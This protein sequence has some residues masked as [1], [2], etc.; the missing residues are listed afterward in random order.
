MDLNEILE[1]LREERA[2]IDEAIIVLERMQ[3]GRG[4]RRGRPPK[5]VQE[6][7]VDLPAPSKRRGR[8]RNDSSADAA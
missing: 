3:L 4:R 2:Q 7:K 1:Q 8:P 6:A 5:W